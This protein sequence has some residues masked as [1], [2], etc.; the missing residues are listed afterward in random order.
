MCGFP[1]DQDEVFRLDER[2]YSLLEAMDVYLPIL[3]DRTG[4]VARTFDQLLD[5]LMEGK[6]GLAQGALQHDDFLRP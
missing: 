5:E 2:M 4:K 3:E 1:H 6:K